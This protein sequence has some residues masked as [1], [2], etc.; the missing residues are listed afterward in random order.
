MLE[1]CSP[2]QSAFISPSLSDDAASCTPEHTGIQGKKE[3]TS[4]SV[5]LE[6]KDVLQ[7]TLLKVQQALNL[8]VL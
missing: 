2:S 7:H 1:L 4:Y 5:T 8:S 6:A 3:D